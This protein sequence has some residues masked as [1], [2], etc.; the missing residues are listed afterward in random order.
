MC[1][2]SG[3]SAP[4]RVFM[5][6]SLG[7]SKPGVVGPGAWI[8]CVGLCFSLT[9]PFSFLLGT[10]GVAGD[11]IATKI[12]EL[13]K[14]NRV[15]MAESEGAKTRVKQQSKHIQELEREVRGLGHSCLRRGLPSPWATPPGREP[16]LDALGPS[17]GL[18]GQCLR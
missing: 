12:V 15:L 9:T 14:K 2:D 6:S 13:S 5:P 18:V 8:R 4:P 11:A 3:A 1:G 7:F 17:E 16:H 10:A